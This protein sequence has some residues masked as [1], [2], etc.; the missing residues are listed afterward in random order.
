MVKLSTKCHWS[1]FLRFPGKQ[2]I[3]KQ[4][5]IKYIA[6]LALLARTAMYVAVCEINIC[7]YYLY[8]LYSVYSL[9]GAVLWK[10]LWTTRL[11]W[12]NIMFNGSIRTFLDHI[13]SIFT[14]IYLMMGECNLYLDFSHSDY[15]PAL[16]QQDQWQGCKTCLIMMIV[17]R[18]TGGQFIRNSGTSNWPACCLVRA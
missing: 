5:Q 7:L 16:T 3:N 4:Y 6:S 10:P 9:S 18:R 13:H 12:H 15:M 17:V 2:Q 8:T 14:F 11:L 1:L